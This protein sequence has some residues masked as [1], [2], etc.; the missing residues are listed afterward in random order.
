MADAP[1]NSTPAPAPGPRSEE[2]IL[3]DPQ[4]RETLAGYQSLYHDLFLKS[5]ARELTDLHR[6]G[7]GYE[8][9]LEYLL[10]QHDKAARKF[11][12]TIQHQKLFDLECQWRAE[13]VD[14]PGA[15]IT[16]DFEDWHQCIEQCG[17][18][19]AVSAD[20]LALLDAFL[21]QLTTADDVEMDNPT[22]AFWQQRRYPNRAYA[23]KILHFFSSS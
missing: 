15:R 12:W 14:V 3:A 19:P 1:E 9:S 21:G 18:V 7:D 4:L 6:N 23:S 20:E 11:L 5:Y 13:L 2:E 17:A 16:A 10:H 8:S 22:R